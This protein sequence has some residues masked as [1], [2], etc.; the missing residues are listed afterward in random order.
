MLACARSTT[1]GRSACGRST[2][3]DLLTKTQTAPVL[4]FERSND[5]LDR[6]IVS[7][8]LHIYVKIQDKMKANRRKTFLNSVTSTK[9][10]FPIRPLII[11]TKS[12]WIILYQVHLMFE[13]DLAVENESQNLGLLFSIPI[14]KTSTQRILKKNSSNNETH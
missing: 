1:S 14:L 9:G 6:E 2:S 12:F 10:L 3:T 8:I 13:Y 7:M 5:C 11:S 4:L